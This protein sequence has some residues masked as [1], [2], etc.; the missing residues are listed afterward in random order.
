MT[1]MNKQGKLLSVPLVA[2][3]SIRRTSGIADIQRKDQKRVITV[4]GDVQGR[5]ASEVLQEVKTTLAS[6]ELPAGYS[7]RYSGQ[8][9]EQSKAAAFLMQA[10][11]VTLLMVFLILVME[12]NSVKVPFVI[13]LS[14]PLSL[15]GVFIGLILTM[16]P[17]SVIMTGVGV[18]ALAGA[19]GLHQA[20]PRIRHDPGRG[21]L[22]GRADTPAACTAH[23]SNHRARHCPP[24]NRRGLRLATIS[25]RGG[26]GKRRFLA[27]A[28]Y[29]HHFRADDVNLSDA[30][31]HSHLLLADGDLADQ[32]ESDGREDEQQVQT[33]PAARGM[34][35]LWKDIA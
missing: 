18:I 34:T 4:S 35:R 33:R 28:R 2:V 5:V 16:T 17:F 15:I 6:L 9:E 19:P 25:S 7:I 13:M 8:D 29:R 32:T 30:D 20:P 31:H 3:A 21:A 1:F 26:S 22:G 10:L 14:V 27:S 23:G 12:F 24:G 11:V